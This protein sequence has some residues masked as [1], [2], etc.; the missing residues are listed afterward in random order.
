MSS[1]DLDQGGFYGR[2]SRPAAPASR[3]S[4]ECRHCGSSLAGRRQELRQTTIGGV[5]HIVEVFRC[6]CGH[7]RHVRRPV[8]RGAAAG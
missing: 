8:D 6:P 2:V 1:I 3:G 7:G 5:A 4:L